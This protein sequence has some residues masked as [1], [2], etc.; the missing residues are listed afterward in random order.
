MYNDN[1]NVFKLPDDLKN[2]ILK[3]Y[4][5]SRVRYKDKFPDSSEFMS[6]EAYTELYLDILQYKQEHKEKV[7]KHTHYQRYYW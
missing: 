7:I 5:K 4:Q 1:I 2:A 6:L 3:S